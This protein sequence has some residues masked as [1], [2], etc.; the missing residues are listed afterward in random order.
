MPLLRMLV[1]SPPIL[2]SCF[3]IPGFMNAVPDPVCCS[4]SCTLFLILYA[5]PNSCMLCL[6]LVCCAWFLNALLDSWMLFSISARCSLFPT[7]DPDFCMLLPDSWMLFLI[8]ECC[9][10]FLNAVP[11][12]RMLFL[13]PECCSWYVNAIPDLECCSCF[14]NA[15]RD[16]HKLFIFWTVIVNK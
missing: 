14:L 7:D 12:T 1:L 5:V 3:L 6:I 4:W 16:S 2:D 8:P 9:F 10:L 15:G 13:I 11:D